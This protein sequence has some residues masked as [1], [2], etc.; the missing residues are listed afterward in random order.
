MLQG[1]ER[2]LRA[3][4]RLLSRFDLPQSQ[5]QA[6]DAARELGHCIDESIQLVFSIICYSVR[7][8]TY[9]E[10]DDANVAF[11]SFDGA[12]VSCTFYC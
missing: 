11:F 9:E 1:V 7:W 6:L 5:V 12:C 10:K 8:T 3:H 4:Q 2:C